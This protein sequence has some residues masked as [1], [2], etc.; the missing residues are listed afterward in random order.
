M[1]IFFMLSWLCGIV[2]NENKFILEIY[3]VLVVFLKFV[4][5]WILNYILI[6]LLLILILRGLVFIFIILIKIVL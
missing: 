4:Y 1:I 6:F 3:D 5:I 2:G